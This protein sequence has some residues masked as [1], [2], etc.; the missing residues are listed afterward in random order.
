MTVRETGV[1]MPVMSVEQAVQRYR[2]T[3]KLVSE[4]MEKDRDYGIIPGTGNKPTLLKPGAEKLTTFFGLR[5]RFVLLDKL[6]DWDAGR[7]MYRYACEL[8]SGDMLIASTE[9][10]ANSMEKKYRWR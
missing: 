4:A 10:S 9:A 6:E 8:W 2:A 1:V 7:F 5:S 3:A